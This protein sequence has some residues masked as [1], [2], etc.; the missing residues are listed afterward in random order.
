MA[1]NGPDTVIDGP[2]VAYYPIES[3]GLVSME[4]EKEQDEI[5]NET[6]RIDKPLRTTQVGTT[7]R[8]TTQSCHESVTKYKKLENSVSSCPDNMYISRDMRDLT[9]VPQVESTSASLSLM[10][11]SLR[12]ADLA[13]LSDM[14]VDDQP[15]L[16]AVSDKRSC[17]KGSLLKEASPN[18]QVLGEQQT[19]NMQSFHSLGSDDNLMN[20]I[21]KSFLQRNKKETRVDPTKEGE[22]DQENSVHEYEVIEYSI[23]DD[24]HEESEYVCID[25]SIN[26]NFAIHDDYIDS[27]YDASKL[28]SATLTDTGSDASVVDEQRLVSSDS[29]SDNDDDITA[30]EPVAIAEVT[31]T[32]TSITPELT[33]SQHFFDCFNQET[34]INNVVNCDSNTEEP[35]SDVKPLKQDQT[36]DPS[37]NS[38]DIVV[39]RA[40]NMVRCDVS[41]MPETSDDIDDPFANEREH[42]SINR[43]NENRSRL[44]I[45]T[46]STMIVMS[47][48]IMHKYL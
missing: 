46:L 7:N 26:G 1:T 16:P 34:S 11:P 4:K 6:E 10:H 18:V 13:D 47:S 25:Y 8:M 22:E 3:H 38:D 15:V 37:G 24:T 33:Q 42:Q 39:S 43:L 21:I 28:P 19:P 27:M 41:E 48:V 32:A 2:D 45:V 14:Y 44:S 36:P 35:F 40:G 29:D 9:M 20:G 31:R 17:P 30:S 12:E 23:T 5:H